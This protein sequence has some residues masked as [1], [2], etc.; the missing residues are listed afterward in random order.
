MNCKCGEELALPALYIGKT[1]HGIPLAQFQCKCGQATNAQIDSMKPYTAKS[2]KG[3]PPPRGE[4]VAYDDGRIQF[5]CPVCQGT[6]GIVAPIHTVDKDGKVS[7][8][9]V[10][11]YGCGFHTW[12]TLDEWKEQ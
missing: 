3:F 10:C 1:E 2:G 7:P 4:Y 9:F 8:S 11:P 6:T 12:M 5:T